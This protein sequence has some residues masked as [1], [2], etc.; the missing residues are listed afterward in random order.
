MVSRF[1]A[2]PKAK[3]QTA[4]FSPS[5][6][7][8]GR[9]NRTIIVLATLA[10]LG[11]SKPALAE[12]PEPGLTGPY[13][14]VLRGANTQTYGL[15]WLNT[16]ADQSAGQWYL[17]HSIVKWMGGDWTLYENTTW[18]GWWHGTAWGLPQGFSG[19]GVYAASKGVI[20]GNVD[21]PWGLFTV[22]AVPIVD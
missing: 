8:D 22:L 1:G 3:H 15:L 5:T 11:L 12:G 14:M 21:T 7:G 2:K 13:I 18:G 17:Y 10:V 6:K 4:F 20:Y 19:S 16:S 9:M